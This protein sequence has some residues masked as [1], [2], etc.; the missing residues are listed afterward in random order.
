MFAR[1]L[2]TAHL[3]DPLMPDPLMVLQGGSIMMDGLTGKKDLPFPIMDTV[4]TT[5]FVWVVWYNLGNLLA[6]G[7]GACW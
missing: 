1:P 4:G 5:L 6:G 3:P 2:L 7:N